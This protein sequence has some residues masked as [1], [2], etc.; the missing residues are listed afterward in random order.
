L[1]RR[2][3]EER[4]GGPADNDQ[5]AWTFS[6]PPIDGG[7]P[8]FAAFKGGIVLLTNTANFCGYT[9]QDQGLAGADTPDRLGR[10]TFRRC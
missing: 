4:F 7:R 5:S 8:N 6:F 2:L 3:P 10:K 1:K 9:Y